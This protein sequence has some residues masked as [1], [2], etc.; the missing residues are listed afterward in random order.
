MYPLIYFKNL[1]F[2]EKMYDM[3]KAA[4]CPCPCSMSQHIENTV[5]CLVTRLAVSIAWT[6]IRRTFI[7]HNLC[8]VSEALLNK[9]AFCTED[10]RYQT[11]KRDKANLPLL[12]LP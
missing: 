7:E 5:T 1:R 9:L 11:H 4:S 3:T 10:F 8:S 6:V 2:L 12:L